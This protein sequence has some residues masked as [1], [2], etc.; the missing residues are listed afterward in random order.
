MIL[1]FQNRQKIK[2]DMELQGELKPI[3]DDAFDYALHNT[4]LLVS[5]NATLTTQSSFISDVWGKGITAFEYLV[6]TPKITDKDLSRIRKNLTDEL[7]NYAQTK[8]L[9]SYNNHPIFV[10]SDIWLSNNHLHVD[11]AYVSNAE[12]LAYIN[13]VAKS[14]RT[15]AKKTRF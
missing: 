11:V 7:M 3:V 1:L 13:D 2:K 10:I 12:T 8:Q 4:Q 14:D 5:Q 6:D 15:I 9:A